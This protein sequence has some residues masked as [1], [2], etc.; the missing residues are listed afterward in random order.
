MVRPSSRAGVPVFSR[1]KREAQALQRLREL[2]RG[3]FNRIR[4]EVGR[5]AAALAAR[6]TGWNP[7]FTEV[8]QPAQERACRQHDAAGRDFGTRFGQDSGTRTACIQ[9]DIDNRVA[10]D[11]EVGLLGQQRL[12]GLA[13]ELAIGL[14]ARAAHGRPLGKI[15]GAELDAGA[16]DGAAHDAVQG[17]DLAHQMALAQ[18]ADGGIAGH[19]ADRVDAGA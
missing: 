15:E 18:P 2:C 11:L 10:A 5:H 3:F 16:V 17:I 14:G 13:V 12:H 6:A 1:P 9:K 7:C 19:L 8:N 4:R